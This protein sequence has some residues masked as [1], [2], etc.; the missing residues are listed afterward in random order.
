MLD[1]AFRL[2]LIDLYSELSDNHKIFVAFESSEGV[3]DIGNIDMFTKMLKKYSKDNM[4]LLISNFNNIEYLNSLISNTFEN[5]TNK[6]L[7][8]ISISGKEN[9]DK[10]LYN[11]LWNSLVNKGDK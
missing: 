10:E 11:K 8:F 9:I 6:I 3:F 2:A 5:D 1:Y 7:N 4:L